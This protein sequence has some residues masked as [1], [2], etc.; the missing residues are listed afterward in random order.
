MVIDKVD[1]DD[2]K[3][4]FKDKRKKRS[5]SRR[6]TAILSYHHHLTFTSVF[7]SSPFHYLASPNSPLPPTPQTPLF[8]RHL[9]SPLRPCHNC[10][11][12][13]FMFFM[14]ILFLYFNI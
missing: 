2:L 7:L 3:K 12:N 13:W 6:V 9:P 1:L 4:R 14:F 8:P 11:F 10:N 5:L